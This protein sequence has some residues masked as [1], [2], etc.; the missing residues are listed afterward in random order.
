MTDTEPTSQMAAVRRTHWILQRLLAGACVSV[1][2]VCDEFG[3]SARQARRYLYLL[4]EMYALESFRAE[5]GGRKYY[6]VDPDHPIDVAPSV[7]GG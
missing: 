6:T 4:K 3:C 7:R 2:D 5:G 1:P